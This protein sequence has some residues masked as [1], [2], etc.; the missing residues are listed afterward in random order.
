MGAFHPCPTSSAKPA[1]TCLVRIQQSALTTSRSP[2]NIHCGRTAPPSVAGYTFLRA[3][4]STRPG[5]TP[6]SSRAARKYGR[7]SRRPAVETRL[8]ERLE[9]GSFRYST[10]VWN[11]AGTQAQLRRPKEFA[12]CLSGRATRALR[13][14]PESDCRACHESA[15]DR[16]WRKRATALAG[17]D[18]LA[19]HA[20]PPAPGDPDLQ[21]LWRAGGCATCPTHC[22][23]AATNQRP[24]AGIP[25]G[26]WLPA[27]Q[28]R[29]L[30]QRKRSPAPWI[31]V[32]HSV[33]QTR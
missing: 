19:P 4:S 9:D 15:A 6:G 14:P 30:P 28:L 27:R 21:A 33:A 5:R 13:H 10:Y 22:A 2:R 8:I 25:R 32:A 11:E 26:A 31:S 29:P 1:F 16:A 20:E 7:S 12:C 23:P 24:V 3:L 18:P 17:R